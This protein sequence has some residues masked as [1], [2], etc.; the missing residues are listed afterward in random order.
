MTAFI[1]ATPSVDGISILY[2]QNA[3]FHPMPVVAVFWLGPAQAER[4]ECTQGLAGMH[5]LG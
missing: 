5:T 3:N 2:L 1:A 4:R